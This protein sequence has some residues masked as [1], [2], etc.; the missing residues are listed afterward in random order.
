EIRYFL[1]W[2]YWEAEDYYRAAVLGDFLARRY[3]DLASASSSAKIAMA[4]Y[5]HLYN[6]ALLRKTKKDD[7]DFESQRMAQIAEFIT[8][9]WPGTDTAD[10]AF[11]IL[12]TFAIHADKPEDAEKLLKQVSAQ[13][14]PRLELMLG[15]ALWARYLELSQTSQA[16]QPETDQLTKLKATAVKYMNSGFDVEKKESPLSEA[17]VTAALYL[18]QAQLSDNDYPAAIASLE[19]KDNG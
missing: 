7:G 19:D 3:P 6:D 4:S 18:V 1:C 8:R 14:R 15:N 9:R 10:A 16:D 11:G 12:V 5:E 2:L 13:S 17:A